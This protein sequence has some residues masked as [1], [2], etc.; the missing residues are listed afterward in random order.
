MKKRQLSGTR[1]IA[2]FAASVTFSAFYF[3]F[4]SQNERLKDPETAK[5][6]LLVLFL[7]WAAIMALIWLFFRDLK[8]PSESGD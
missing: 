7:A 8:D 1:K 4:L 6:E 2:W 3:W 5:P